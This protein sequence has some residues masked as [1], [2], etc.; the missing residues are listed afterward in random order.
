MKG[1]GEKTIMGVSQ[2]KRG[3]QIVQEELKKK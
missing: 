1:R 3:V 2:Y